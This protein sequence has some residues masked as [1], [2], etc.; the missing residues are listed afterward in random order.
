MLQYISYLYHSCCFLFILKASVMDDILICKP[1]VGCSKLHSFMSV[2]KASENS[3]PS[4][5]VN[6]AENT[7]QLLVNW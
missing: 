6:S 1:R 7:Q 5:H 2:Q 3:A 4:L